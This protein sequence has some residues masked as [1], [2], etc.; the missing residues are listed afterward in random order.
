MSKVSNLNLSPSDLPLLSRTMMIVEK[1]HESVREM[2]EVRHFLSKKNQKK[3][4]RESFKLFEYF[5]NLFAKFLGIEKTL[6]I[7]YCQR[8]KIE[9]FKQV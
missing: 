4:E 1:K 6:E 8:I 3:I 9:Y 7:D 5:T 2:R